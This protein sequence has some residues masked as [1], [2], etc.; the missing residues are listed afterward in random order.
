MSIT[1]KIECNFDTGNLKY[2]RIKQRRLFGLYLVGDYK[3]NAIRE[4]NKRGT[5]EDDEKVVEET[6]LYLTNLLCHIEVLPKHYLLIKEIYDI[7]DS[8]I[9]RLRNTDVKTWA[10]TY[11]LCG[12]YSG[13]NINIR[14]TEENGDDE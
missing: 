11:S 9:Y 10:R 14:V 12:E 4:F 5:E 13:T 1:V 2:Y 6:V 8:A 3:Y 7:F